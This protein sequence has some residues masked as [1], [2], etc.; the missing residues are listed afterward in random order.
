MK[1][2]QAEQTLE[3][4]LEY[5]KASYEKEISTLNDRIKDENYEFTK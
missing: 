4:K 2:R 3:E 1:L 5:L